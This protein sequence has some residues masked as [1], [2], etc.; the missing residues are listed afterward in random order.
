MR[1]RVAK[2]TGK[3]GIVWQL[4]KSIGLLIGGQL[5]AIAPSACNAPVIGRR[6]RFLRFSTT[7][8]LTHRPSSTRTCSKRVLRKASH[9][10][11][12]RF[13][14]LNSTHRRQQRVVVPSAA[15]GASGGPAS[16]QSRAFLEKAVRYVTSP[17]LRNSNATN[18]FGLLVVAVGHASLTRGLTSAIAF[19]L[20][21]LHVVLALTLTALPLFILMPLLS[22]QHSLIESGAGSCWV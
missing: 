20:Q 7:F 2:R 14:S 5:Q 19:G 1:I 4:A 10:P 15:L 13:L 9:S 6:K 8:S 21:C 3:S 16:H 17:L 18:L 11:C 22:F 12:K